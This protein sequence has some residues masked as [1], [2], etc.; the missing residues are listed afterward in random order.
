ML[1]PR[2]CFIN[3]PPAPALDLDPAATEDPAQPVCSWRPLEGAAEGVGGGPYLARAEMMASATFF[4]ASAYCLNSIVYV[5]RPC[6][7]ERS[8]VE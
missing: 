2:P 7:A 3:A 5:A 4:G 8:E 1:T 6:V